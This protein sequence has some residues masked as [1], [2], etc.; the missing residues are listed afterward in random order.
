M[1]YII[2]LVILSDNLFYREPVLNRPA[3]TNLGRNHYV[4]LSDHVL[5]DEVFTTVL[6]ISFQRCLLAKD[7]HATPQSKAIYLNKSGCHLLPTAEASVPVER[8]NT[9][10]LHSEH[11]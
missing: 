6:T 9:N 3:L 4:S 7:L 10:C 1:T 8:L 2:I 11:H 5:L